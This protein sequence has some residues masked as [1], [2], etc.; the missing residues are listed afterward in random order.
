MSR[1]RIE[2]LLLATGFLAMA[3][4]YARPQIVYSLV[5][6]YQLVELAMPEFAARVL[7]G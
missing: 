1:S 6:V 5:F 3:I 2:P 7:G 4:W